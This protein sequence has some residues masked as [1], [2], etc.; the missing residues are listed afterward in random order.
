MQWTTDVTT[1]CEKLGLMRR[2]VT[3]NY[4]RRG[5]NA[6]LQYECVA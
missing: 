4:G 1:E 5:G 6:G 2:W 3:S